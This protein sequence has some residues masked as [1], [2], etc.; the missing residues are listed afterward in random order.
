MTS[1]TLTASASRTSASR[2]FD[3]ISSGEY[4]FPD[5]SYLL[6][7][8]HLFLCSWLPSKGAGQL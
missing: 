7:Y 2:N 5:I 8:S 1:P 3:M 4:H 6:E